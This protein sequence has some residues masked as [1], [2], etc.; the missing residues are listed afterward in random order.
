MIRKNNSHVLFKKKIK[1]LPLKYF[2]SKEESGYVKDSSCAKIN[3][4]IIIKSMSK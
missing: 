2:I 3:K 1:N 4:K